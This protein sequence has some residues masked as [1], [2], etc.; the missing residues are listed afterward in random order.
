MIFLDQQKAFDWVEWGWVDHVLSK[1]NFGEQFREWVQMLFKYA[2]TCI[3][4]N[5]FVSKYFYISRSCR[6]GY[7]ITPLVYILKA[8]PVA[9]A[10]RGGSEIQ[11]VKLRGGKM[12]NI[13]RLSSAC[14]QMTLSYLIKMMNVK[15]SFDILT[16]YEKASGSKVN[17]EKT[18][19]MY[20]GSAKNN[21]PKFTKIVWKKNNVKTLGI[22]HGYN[23]Q[24]DEIWKSII[25]KMKNCVHVWKSRNLT[26]TSRTASV[27]GE[28]QSQVPVT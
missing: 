23:I 16:I 26:Y 4:T 21:R 5:G 22:H 10:I 20:I 2:H 17:Y 6:K 3:K 28:L 14:L 24:N 11:G 18:K 12:G 13:S 15:K 7:P 25:D 1:F 9:C 8:E 19:G 27:T